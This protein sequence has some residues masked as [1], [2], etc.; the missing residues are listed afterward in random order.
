M[1]KHFVAAA[2]LLCLA[3]CCTTPHTQGGSFALAGTSWQRNDD[4]DANPHG[5]TLAFEAARASGYTG[6]NNWFAAFTHTDTA[7]RFGPIGMTRMACQTEMQTATE[8]NFVA[9]LEHTR[10]Y[11]LDGEELVF[12]SDDDSVI[13]R[14]T[15][16]Q[17]PCPHAP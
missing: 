5:A 2:L 16:A 4:A 1:A 14:F 13:A 3:A 9:A 8:R 17:E 7:L 15:C 6:C 10:G 11:H 12:T